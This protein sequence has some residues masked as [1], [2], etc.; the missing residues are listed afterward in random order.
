MNPKDISELQYGLVN[1]LALPKSFGA[2]SE[3][4]KKT[5]SNHFGPQLCILRISSVIREGSE[6]PF[7]GQVK[8]TCQW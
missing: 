3:V 6:I 5:H 1:Y 7:P 2:Y 4:Q 8:I